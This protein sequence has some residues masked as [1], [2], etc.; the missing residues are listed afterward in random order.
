MYRVTL[1]K[2]PTPPLLP[3]SESLSLLKLC[4]N[5]KMAILSQSQKGGAK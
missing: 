4:I 2:M 3:T 5:G 1:I